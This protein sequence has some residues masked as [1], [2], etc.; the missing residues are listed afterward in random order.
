MAP[1]Q[2]SE[3]LDRLSEA[4]LGVP[5]SEAEVWSR[6]ESRLNKRTRGI[7]IWRVAAVLLAGMVSIPISLQEQVHNRPLNNDGVAAVDLPTVLPVEVNSRS[8][9]LVEA[10]SEAFENRRSIAQTITLTPRKIEV[11][12]AVVQVSALALTPIDLKE[13]RIAQG[14]F[15][16]QDISI[17]QASLE[18]RNVEQGR[19]MT[20]RAQWQNSSTISNVEFQA[21]KIKLY[22][23]NE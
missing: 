20:I 14:Q 22:E 1:N 11:Q 19:N 4:D 15:S 16:A 17:I 12:L 6:L 7:W 3:K 10:E 18:T 5:F 8:S 21:L 2:L 23:K 13:E 9:K